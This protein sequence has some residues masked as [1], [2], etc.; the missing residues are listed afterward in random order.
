M[1]LFLAALQNIDDSINEAAELDGASEWRK[2]R[3]ITVP[4][5]R[6]TIFTIVTLGLIGTWQIF[7]QIYVGTKGSPLNTTLTPAFLSFNASFNSNEW[8]VGAALAF[9]LFAIIVFFTVITRI[10]T[11]DRDRVRKQRFTRALAFVGTRGEK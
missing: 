10:V 7:D 9:I 1:L 8:G 5:I 11:R 2:F 4:M 3:H 6:P